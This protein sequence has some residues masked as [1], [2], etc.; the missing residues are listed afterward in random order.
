MGRMTHECGLGPQDLGPYLLGHLPTEEA[1]RVEH[2]LA[3]CPGC[4][5][6][7]ARLRPVVTAMA[8]AVPV[9]GPPPSLP[10]PSLDR[11]LGAI[12]QQRR[13]S[14][15]N[16]R[17]LLAVA[18]VVI[19]VA[20]TGAGFVIG[21]SR[22][23]PDGETVRLASPTGASAR[24]VL[25][26][27]GWGTA[28][29]LDVRGL[30]PGVTYGAWLARR[31]GKRVPAGSFRPDVHGTAKLVLAAALSRSDSGSMGVTALGGADVLTAR[32]PSRSG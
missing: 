29:T 24:V 20:F 25:D 28:V 11:V 15:G 14:T 31:D 16:R 27:R 13:W 32:L 8:V 21:L 30:N 4:A 26:Q 1:A 6:E 7:V 3:Q 5:D 22:Q 19:A 9:E 23:R 12:A 18:A 17:A 2:G 10:A